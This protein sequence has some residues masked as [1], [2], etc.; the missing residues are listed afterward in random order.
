MVEA[1]VRREAAELLTVGGCYGEAGGAQARVNHR[2]EKKVGN[3]GGDLYFTRDVTDLAKSNI[4]RKVR[5]R[6][7]DISHAAERFSPYWLLAIALFHL[8]ISFFFSAKNS[9]K[10]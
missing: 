10:R 3:G 4:K 9:S 7:S 1:R 8:L 5:V 6:E 2:S